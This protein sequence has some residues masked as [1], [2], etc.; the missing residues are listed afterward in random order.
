VPLRASTP[1]EAFQLF[2]THINRLLNKV[3]TQYR[4]QFITFGARQE[5]ASLSFRDRRRQP[6]AVP[7][8]SSPWYLSLTQELQTVAEGKEYTL[9]TVQYAYRIQRTTSIQEEAEVRFEYVS[10]HKDPEARWCRHH[11]Q[12]HRDYH[13]VREEFSPQKLHIPTG[14]VTIENVIRFLITDLGVP[15]L[16][17]NWDEVLRESEKQFR[18][19]TRWNE[20]EC[21]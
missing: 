14:W 5:Q 11:V 10:R 20:P 6:T 3:L 2:Q 18:E 19:W 1:H 17:E 16:T 12:F 7:L 4:L 15:P 9:R 13:D 8:R 21:G